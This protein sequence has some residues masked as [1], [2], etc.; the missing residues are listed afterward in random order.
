MGG[1]RSSMLIEGATSD[2]NEKDARLSQADTR[3]YISTQLEGLYPA[4]TA[5]GQICLHRLREQMGG[6]MAASLRG[7]KIPY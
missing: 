6:F 5:L 2:T 4:I 3:H 7:S 1:G